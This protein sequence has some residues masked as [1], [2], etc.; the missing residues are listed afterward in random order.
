MGK[1][2]LGEGQGQRGEREYGSEAGRGEKLL[3]GR[4]A[5][6]SMLMIVVDVDDV[7]SDDAPTELICLLASLG[8]Q[9]AGAHEHPN[10][11]A[12]MLAPMSTL[13]WAPASWH[14]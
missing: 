1:R 5:K 4:A 6:L 2:I 11:G 9:H 8:R 7:E 14:P 3:V 13:T 12:S 10:L